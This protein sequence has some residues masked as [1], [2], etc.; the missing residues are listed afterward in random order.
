MLIHPL[1]IKIRAVFLILLISLAAAAAPK[2]DGPSGLADLKAQ[3]LKLRN[4]D[5]E[6]KQRDRWEELAAKL[7][8]WTLRTSD[9]SEQADALYH[10]ALA[11]EEIARRLHETSSARL[12][13]SLF[14]RFSN[15]Y[16]D[17]SRH[18]DARIKSAK[19]EEELLTDTSAAKKIYTEI[20]QKF[21]QSDAAVFARSKLKVERKTENTSPSQQRAQPSPDDL[22]LPVVV[23]DPGH[24]GD[25]LGATGPGGLLEKDVALAIA[26]QVR[27][28]ALDQ[29]AFRVIL[30]RDVDKFVPLAARTEKA[31]SVNGKLFISIHANASPAHNLSGLESYF[32][33]NTDDAASK[34]LAEIENT[35]GGENASSDLDFILSDMIQGAKIPQSSE[36]ATNLGSA[37]LK[38]IVQSG[39]REFKDHGVKKAPFFVLVGA[40]MPCVLIEVAY[41]D[42]PVDGA[43][44]AKEEFR[45]A[46]AQGIVSGVKRHLRLSPKA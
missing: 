2:T 8:A 41:I 37:V 40:R 38:S 28:I 42:N 13:L 22:T 19:I 3:L 23:I 9:R 30:T 29:G 16:S 18:L 1:I 31:N 45:E 32:L 44:L 17:D 43:E 11:Y 24:G 36:L 4:T 46:I 25:D 12:A 20:V 27:K 34:R 21:P 6:V 33:D 5:L 35:A 14:S 7:E 26:L 15:E 39:V 10:S